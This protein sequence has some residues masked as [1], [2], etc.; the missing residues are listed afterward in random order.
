MAFSPTQ[1]VIILLPSSFIGMQVV[2]TVL[3]RCEA[4]IE[5]QFII[6]TPN[7]SE[8]HKLTTTFIGDD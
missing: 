3:E 7:F 5:N 1:M 4:I 8:N 6:V 2:N